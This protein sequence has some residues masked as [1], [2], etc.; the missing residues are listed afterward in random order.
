MLRNL[1][2]YENWLIVGVALY[3]V[4]DAVFNGHIDD[5]DETYGYWEPLHYLLYK[6]GMQTWEYSPQYGIR[7]Y[8]FI[9]PSYLCSSFLQHYL[10]LEKIALFNSIKL[11]LG[12]LYLYSCLQLVQSMKK[13]VPNDMYKIFFLFLT[14]SP[15]LSPAMSFDLITCRQL[16]ACIFRCKKC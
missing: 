5:T 3:I 4:V 1:L 16:T 6:V 10:G 9:L 7:S 8:A 13:V 14:F 12:L 2:D 15:G 11:C